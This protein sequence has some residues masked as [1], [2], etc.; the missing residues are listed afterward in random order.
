ML[1][2]STTIS[3]TSSTL[4]ALYIIFSCSSKEVGAKKRIFDSIFLKFFKVGETYGYS[5]KGKTISRKLATDRYP[6]VWHG[7]V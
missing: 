3:P 2:V 7:L 5:T 1:K 4:M 6:A